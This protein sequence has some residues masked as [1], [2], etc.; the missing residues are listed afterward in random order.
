VGDLPDSSS[1]ASS[2]KI[3]E[4]TGRLSSKR[5]G[6]SMGTGDA[7]TV[8]I[9]AVDLAARRM[10]LELVAVRAPVVITSNILPRERKREDGQG[11]KVKQGKGRTKASNQRRKSSSRGKRKR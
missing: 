3:N 1:R 11:R 7:V 10:D 4:S 5:A 9:M 8:R 6:S 2:W